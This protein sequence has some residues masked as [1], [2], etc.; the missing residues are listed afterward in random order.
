[1]SG[2][3]QEE[4]KSYLIDLGMAEAMVEPCLSVIGEVESLLSHPIERIFI[5]DYRDEEGNRLYESMWLITAGQISEI[6]G[7]FTEQVTFDV[8]PVRLGF[9]RL[10]VSHEHFKLTDASAEDQARL[11]V[12]VN[13]STH[14]NS[15][16]AGTF[17]ASGANCVILAEIMREH[18]LPLLNTG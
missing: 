14:S 5:S 15:A 2:L 7:Y 3:S 18:L 6:H 12:E 4:I 9:A 1:V 10:Q 11:A 13:I 8:V 16:L 17:K